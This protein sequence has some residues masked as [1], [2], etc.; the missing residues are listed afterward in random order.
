ML[1]NQGR[2]HFQL[3]YIL[4]DHTQVYHGP[5]LYLE[6]KSGFHWFMGNLEAQW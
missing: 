4:Q 2:S 6:A 1:I 5:T 3:P